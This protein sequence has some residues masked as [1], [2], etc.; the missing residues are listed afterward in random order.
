MILVELLC[1]PGRGNRALVSRETADML[2]KLNHARL[3]EDDRPKSPVRE[4][5][6]QRR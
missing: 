4:A 6:R 5:S 2:V 1:V 3:L